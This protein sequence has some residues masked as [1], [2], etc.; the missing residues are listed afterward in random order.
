MMGPSSIL[1]LIVDVNRHLLID[2][3]EWLRGVVGVMASYANNLSLGA[4]SR[5]F[6][7]LPALPA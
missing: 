2:P 1:N 3:W 4:N 7:D 5:A 6:I